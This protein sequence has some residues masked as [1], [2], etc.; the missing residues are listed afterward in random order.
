[1]SEAEQGAQVNVALQVAKS[2]VG[3]RGSFGDG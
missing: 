1:M 3:F 2:A